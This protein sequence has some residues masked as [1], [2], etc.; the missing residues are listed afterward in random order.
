[1]KKIFSFVL[2]FLCILPMFSESENLIFKLTDN[3]LEVFS[4]DKDSKS[5]TF[6]GSD[7]S[8][9]RNQPFR[10]PLSEGGLGAGV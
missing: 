9:N 4:F 5:I 7:N 2:I 10:A 8:K 1:M 3:T 6:F